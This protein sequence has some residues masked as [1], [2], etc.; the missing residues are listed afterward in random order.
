LYIEPY[1]TAQQLA[2]ISDIVQGGNY[3]KLSRCDRISINS[4]KA[5]KVK[6]INVILYSP[7]NTGE[8]LSAAV[9]S[10]KPRKSVFR[11]LI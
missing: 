9:L 7:K 5:L 8:N 6:D 11:Q 2:E 4:G 1:E 10:F 3:Y